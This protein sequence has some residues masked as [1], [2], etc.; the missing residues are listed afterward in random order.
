M[1]VP[2]GERELAIEIIENFAMDRGF[3][4]GGESGKGR[5]TG[6][7]SSY[8]LKSSDDLVLIINLIGDNKLGVRISEKKT[9]LSSSTIAFINQLAEVLNRKWANSAI[10]EPG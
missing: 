2:T 9:P 4:E 6:V 8:I 7:H 5:I 3:F 1:E 10:V